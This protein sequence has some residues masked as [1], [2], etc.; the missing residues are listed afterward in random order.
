VTEAGLD[1]VFVDDIHLSPLAND[2]PSRRDAF[3][4]G[5]RS[6]RHA[7]WINSATGSPARSTRALPAIFAR[8][9]VESA[10]HP[11]AVIP[12]HAGI[13]YARGFSISIADVSEY[14]NHPH[15]RVMTTVGGRRL[16]LASI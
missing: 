3:F 4:P 13:Q 5:G 14:W 16:P 2:L 8:N 11:T 6:K 15:A 10:L 12:A 1:D 7:Y 9:D